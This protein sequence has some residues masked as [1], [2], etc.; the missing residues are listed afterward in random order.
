MCGIVGVTGRTDD[1]VAS[2]MTATLTHRGPD[3]CGK[4]VSDGIFLGHTRLKVIDLATGDQPMTTADGRHT[5]VF[6]GEIYNFQE[7][8]QELESLGI[9]FRTRSDTEVL[10]Y[11]YATWG[12]EGLHRLR[13]MFAFAVW[14]ALE[15]GLFLA[16]DRLG[17]KPLYYTEVN[18]QLLFA[19]EMKALL[20]HPDVR[21]E[22]DV[23]ALDDYLTYLYVPAP[24]TIFRGIRELLPG[25]WMSWRVG[26]LA[27]ER[28]WDVHFAPEERAEEEYLAELTRILG[29]AVRLRM[30]SDVPLGVFLSGGMD[31]ST[32]TTLMARNTREPIRTFTLDYVDGKQ[33]YSE[34][35]Y[36]YEVVQATGAQAEQLVIEAQSADLLGT[37]T[38]HFDEPYGNP[39][40][41]LLYQLSEA[42]RRFVTVALVGD[43][44][45]ETF[46]GYP[47]YRG[48]ILSERY[49]R[50]PLLFRRLMAAAA[51][52]LREPGD[53]SHFN[54]R[55]REF[56]TGTCLPPQQ[57]YLH[58]V[59]YFGKEMRQRLYSPELR[60]RIG[61]YDPGQF[62]TQLFARSGAE[63]FID[64]INYVDL[65]SFLPYNLL[66]CSD[67]MSM[68][69][70]LEIRVPF[71]DHKLV[72]F[73][74][75][76]PWRFKLRGAETKYLLRRLGQSLLPPGVLKRRKLGLIPPMGLWLRHR[77]GSLVESYL[78]DAEIRKRSYFNP[79]VVGELVRDHQ[80]QRRDYSLHIW[81]LIAFEEWHRQYL[82]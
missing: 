61:D 80:A 32:V 73:L 6:N 69:H 45:D 76:V 72:E 7:V 56:L 70:G 55:V 46:L 27:V 77:L 74:A 53:G 82:D 31:S 22:L 42:S 18:G 64:Q 26:K 75:R 12:K 34:W 65:H 51:E 10:L 57:M 50:V 66:R 5:I 24:R 30:I 59:G 81:A 54:R 8:R 48:A 13:G 79:E 38:R 16:R 3:G 41:L 21:R 37:I 71:T 25:H 9:A 62:L 23:C 49:R 33:H 60:K 58:W 29:D 4:F 20:A 63:E 78:S 67:R 2:R 17:V 44:G 68:A 15:R 40:S 19:S 1:S 36:A 43:A 28:Y 14:D 39:M 52:H 47:R 11:T 35:E